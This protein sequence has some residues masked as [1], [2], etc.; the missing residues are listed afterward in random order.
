MS[1][2]RR[3]HQLYR[4]VLLLLGYIH[5]VTRAALFV[6]SSFRCIYKQ[7]QQSR[8]HYKRHTAGHGTTIFLVPLGWILRVETAPK[9]A[10]RFFRR[11]HRLRTVPNFMDHRMIS[12]PVR[13]RDRSRCH[14]NLNPQQQTNEERSPLTTRF[15]RNGGFL[16]LSGSVERISPW[17]HPDQQSA[18]KETVPGVG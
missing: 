11:P 8:C 10:T 17:R 14:D 13:A 4:L 6:P 5:P 7:Q 2:W 12:T 3:G 1:R 16:F 18:G 9:T 15:R